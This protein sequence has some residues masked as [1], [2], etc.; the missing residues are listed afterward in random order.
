MLLRSREVGFLGQ[1][2]RPSVGFIEQP[3]LKRHVLLVLNLNVVVVPGRIECILYCL[4]DGAD[5]R[6]LLRAA[7]AVGFYFGLRVLVRLAD[8]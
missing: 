4:V 5:V 7:H 8:D 2:S 3:L 6:T 1:V